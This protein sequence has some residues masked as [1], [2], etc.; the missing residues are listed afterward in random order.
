MIENKTAFF[1]RRGKR[2]K[3]KQKLKQEYVFPRT[4]LAAT[5][6]KQ[7]ADTVPR[8]KLTAK[9]TK[10]GKSLQVGQ[11]NELNVGERSYL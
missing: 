10:K 9:K 6:T 3:L 11:L 7:Q 2:Q 4:T 5:K 1:R 8:N